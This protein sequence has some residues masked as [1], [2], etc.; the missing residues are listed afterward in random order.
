MVRIS[1]SGRL[2][3]A[4]RLYPRGVVWHAWSVLKVALKNV[5]KRE[6]CE[7]DER[8]AEH[9]ACQSVSVAMVVSALLTPLMGSSSILLVRKFNFSDT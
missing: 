5:Y 9:S 8:I 6:C 4:A 2:W 1:G 7:F 3:A